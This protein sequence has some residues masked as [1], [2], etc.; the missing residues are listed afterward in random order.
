MELLCVL[1]ACLVNIHC[2]VYKV[3]W[4][5]TDCQTNAVPC[6][7]VVY[8]VM[9]LIRGDVRRFLSVGFVGRSG[10]GAVV[11]I[12]NVIWGH[13]PWNLFCK[14]K[15]EI[16][17]FYSILGQLKSTTVYIVQETTG[18]RTPT[19]GGAAVDYTEYSFEL[20]NTTC[21]TQQL[22]CYATLIGLAMQR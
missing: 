9:P 21:A 7:S 22:V 2:P 16:C 1:R 19:P 17:E 3:I 8:V 13:C 5:K 18:L 15:I 10:R 14:F 6:L 4:F 11:F 20:T 12:Q